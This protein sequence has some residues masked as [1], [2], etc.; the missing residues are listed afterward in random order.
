M[1]L[2]WCLCPPEMFTSC[3][4]GLFILP[5]ASLRGRGGAIASTEKWLQKVAIQ[6]DCSSSNDT[7]LTEQLCGLFSF[8]FGLPSWKRPLSCEPH[9]SSFYARK[10]KI[11]SQPKCPRKSRTNRDVIDSI[12]VFTIPTSRRDIYGRL[13]VIDSNCIDRSLVQMCC[14]PC[15]WAD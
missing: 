11:P 1:A 4:T 2:M 5:S 14:H 6:F 7:V 8:F 13:F 12:D 9:D 3:N 10:M 15:C